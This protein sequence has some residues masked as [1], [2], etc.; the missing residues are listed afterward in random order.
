[1][2]LSSAG[3]A[4]KIS[5]FPCHW[6]EVESPTLTLLADRGISCLVFW[7]PKDS[8]DV[9]LP[10]EKHCDLLPGAKTSMKFHLEGEQEL[11]WALWQSSTVLFSV[12]SYCLSS[13]SSSQASVSHDREKTFIALGD[14]EVA[15]ILSCV[16]TLLEDRAL[17]RHRLWVHGFKG[18]FCFR[19]RMNWEKTLVLSEHFHVHWHFSHSGL[20]KV[21]KSQEVMKSENK[22]SDTCGVILQW[23]YLHQKGKE[24]AHK[25]SLTHTDRYFTLGSL[26]SWGKSCPC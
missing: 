3:W 5:S 17:L 7:I 12:L 15:T 20:Q 19:L 10:G 4:A 26:V 9:F 1:M 2:H 6:G 11:M 8:Q 16:I 24:H 18:W 22:G 23:W 13:H 21:H 14:W 25:H